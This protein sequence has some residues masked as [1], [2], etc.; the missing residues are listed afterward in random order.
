VHNAWTT[1]TVYTMLAPYLISYVPLINFQIQNFESQDNSI[2]SQ[3]LRK[4]QA[5]IILTPLVLVYLFSMDVFFILASVG[6]STIIFI[7]KL[8]TCNKIPCLDVN[9]KM[10]KIYGWLFNMKSMDIEHFRHLRTIS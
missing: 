5:I 3:S 10:D 9:S 4:Y 6:V 1:I 7:L 2:Q 8:L